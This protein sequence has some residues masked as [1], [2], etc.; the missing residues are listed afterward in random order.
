MLFPQRATF[1]QTAYAPICTAPSAC[2]TPTGRRTPILCDAAS[3]SAAAVAPAAAPA[4]SL[5]ALKEW[6]PTCAAIAAGEQTI[7]LRKGGIKEPTFKPAAREFLLFPTSFHTDAQ[8]LK[9][10]AARH[11]AAECAFDPKAQ[12]TLRLGT[13]AALTGAWTTADPSVL[14]LLDGLHVW[15]PGF[16]ENRLRWRA[17]QPITVLELRALRLPQPLELAP[18]DDL[19][20]CFS[21]LDLGASNAEQQLQL[22]A[23][24]ASTVPA[25]GDE[26]FAERQ[27]LCRQQLAQLA[28]LRELPLP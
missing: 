23:D 9:A 20:G 24:A 2:R 13:W 25:L 6:A 28:D 7:L 14:H 10:D 21:W 5:W 17:T 26:A 22:A 3:D 4:A 27:A 16:L 1:Q 12:P 8:L 18:R 15:A 11:Y 19:W